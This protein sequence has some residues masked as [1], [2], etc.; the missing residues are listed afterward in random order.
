MNLGNVILFYF[1]IFGEEKLLGANESKSP[2]RHIHLKK[3]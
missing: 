2:N 3:L 1:G